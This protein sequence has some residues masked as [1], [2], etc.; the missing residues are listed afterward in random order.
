MDFQ[1]KPFAGGLFGGI[2]GVS[3]SHPFDTIR[4]VFQENNY[5][6][7]KKC[8]LDL[9]KQN[10][11]K[12]FYKG[13]KPP[14]IGVGLEKLI[15]FGCYDNFMRMK[16]FDNQISNIFIAGVFSGLCCTTVVTPVDK[17]KIM[18]Q[19][20]QNVTTMNILKKYGIRGIYNGYTATLFR[21]VPGYGIYFA[22]Y[23]NLTKYYGKT[24][25]SPF[26]FGSLSGFMAWLFIY[27]SDPIKTK[28]QNNNIGFLSATQS[29]WRNYGIRGFYRGFSL[30]L[31]RALPLHG[32]VFMG[33]EGIMSLM[34]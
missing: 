11:F 6:S 17:V 8:A 34:E 10:G 33:Y 28:I 7:I 29:I 4:V 27:P 5:N 23:E 16:I 21:E 9:Y 3:A 12:R 19:N 15:V 22:T 13:I 25:W 24:Y 14:L 20:G 31:M 26:L 1:L 2:I 18:L 32:G 30:G